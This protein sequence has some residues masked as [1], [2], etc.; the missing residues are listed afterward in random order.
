MQG[1]WPHRCH[2][3]AHQGKPIQG[4]QKNLKLQC[5]HS[6]RRNFII[7]LPVTCYH[8]EGKKFLVSNFYWQSKE[9]HTS[10]IPAEMY[11]KLHVPSCWETKGSNIGNHIN[12]IFWTQVKGSC[13][14]SWRKENWIFFQ[15]SYHRPSYVTLG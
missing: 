15:F 3:H 7:V 4:A 13:G 6:G 11:E 5:Q 2:T 12:W 9:K 10:N 8:C 1:N 14:P